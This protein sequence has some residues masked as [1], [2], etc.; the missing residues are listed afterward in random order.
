MTNLYPQTTILLCLRT[1]VVKEMERWG[2]DERKLKRQ[3]GKKMVKQ[4]LVEDYMKDVF[5][6]A[7]FDVVGVAEKN[8]VPVLNQTFLV[9]REHQYRPR[10]QLKEV[11]T[12]SPVSDY[13]DPNKT[14]Y[15]L[16]IPRNNMKNSVFHQLSQPIEGRYTKAI[17]TSINRSVPR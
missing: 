5:A 6:A 11:S 10:H 17:K 4:V 13:E 12:E 16:V 15:P 3:Y 2:H 14:N 8:L 9:V 7:A 1:G